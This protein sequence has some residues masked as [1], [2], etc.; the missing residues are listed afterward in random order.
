MNIYCNFTKNIQVVDQDNE[1]Q[2]QKKKRI[3]NFIDGYWYACDC[4]NFCSQYSLHLKFFRVKLKIYCYGQ[5]K[6]SKANYED[7]ELK[8]IKILK[9]SA[10]LAVS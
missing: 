10:N 9:T 2:I 5:E 8:T 6:K 4:N 7:E 1:E 3:V